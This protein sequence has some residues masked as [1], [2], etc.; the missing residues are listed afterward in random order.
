VR[1][2]SIAAALFAAI[3]TGAYALG[4][5]APFAFGTLLSGLLVAGL[6]AALLAGTAYRWLIQRWLVRPLRTLDERLSE[7]SIGNCD[8]TRRV[9]LSRPDEIGAA[10]VHFDAF[11]ARVQDALSGAVSLSL[12]AD[13][14]SSIIA[15]ESQRLATSSSTNAATIE[16]VM[17]TLGE[18]NDLSSK[19]A[20]SCQSAAQGAERAKEA[21]AKG[22]SEVDRLTE[23]MDEI[24]ESS[25]TITKVVGVI[26]D[27]S[28]QTN[29]LALNAAVE[30]ARAGE[31]GKGFAVVAEEVRSLAQRSASA[32]S[33]TSSLIEEACRRAERGGA[34]A[35]EV[36]LVLGQIHSETMQVGRLLG[37]AAEE[38][39]HQSENVGMVTRGLD[40]LGQTSQDNAVSAEEL[41]VASAQSS[42][43]IK[44]LQEL[45]G[46][47][48]VS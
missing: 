38:V 28:F 35:E 23:A 2:T 37:G 6:P 30:A 45:V 34:I 3:G 21:V 39:V 33:E 40:S 1:W 27:V 32:A 11:V 8:L 46:G 16:E 31:A 18:I 24:R 29:L 36:A 9:G 4:A 13:N 20:D 26:Q 10:A 42:A 44:R 7:M 22:N 47:F 12:D 43:Q 25:Q 19:T 5:G 15:T 41:A 17:A 48:R 14:A